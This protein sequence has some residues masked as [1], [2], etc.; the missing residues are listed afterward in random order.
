MGSGLKLLDRF[1]I[2]CILRF[3]KYNLKFN[4]KMNFCFVEYSFL[5]FVCIFVL[6][7]LDDE[8]L[9]IYMEQLRRQLNR[10]ERFRQVS[11]GPFSVARHQN[12]PQVSWFFRRRSLPSLTGTTPTTTITT[13]TTTITS[14]AQ[15]NTHEQPALRYSN[16]IQTLILIN[17]RS[18]NIVYLLRL[19]EMRLMI[20]T[21]VFI[22]VFFVEN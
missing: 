20:H 12:D 4:L 14:T 10:L 16:Q 17:Y 11:F 13:T 9:A 2:E 7:K 6:F 18:I 15:S 19:W 5:L 1:E 22:F 3:I 21:D 8:T